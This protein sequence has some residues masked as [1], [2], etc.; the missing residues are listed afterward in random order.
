MSD[1]LQKRDSFK[2]NDDKFVIK[3][4]ENETKLRV[5]NIKKYNDL[6]EQLAKREQALE[7]QLINATADTRAN[8]EAKL[9]K[10]KATNI[11]ELYAKQV[12]LE[13]KYASVKDKTAIIQQQREQA[14]IAAQQQISKILEDQAAG[15]ISQLDAEKKIAEETAKASAIAADSIRKEQELRSAYHQ[16]VMKYGSDQ[17]KAQIQRQRL[18]ENA[19]KLKQTREAKYQELLLKNK[20]K[21]DKLNKK[22]RKAAEKQLQKEVE[23]DEEVKAVKSEVSMADKL[24]PQF[25]ALEKGLGN[26]IVG[27]LQSLTQDME[28][29]MYIYADKG[30][31]INARLNGSMFTWGALSDKISDALKT[32]SVLNQEKMISSVET[33]VQ[34]GIAEDLAQRAFL[35]SVQ[36]NVAS[37]FDAANGTLLRIIRLQDK[38]ST[39][40]RLGME[41]SLNRFLNGYFEDT[42]YLSETF[43][44][45]TDALLEATSLLTHDASAEFEYQIQKWLGALGSEG[46]SSSSATKIAQGIGYLAS[47]DVSALS[48]DSGLQTLLAL[49][50][51]KAG[52]SYSDLLTGGITSNDINDMLYSMVNYLAEIAANQNNVVKS[53]YAHLLGLTQSDLVA[54]LNLAKNSEALNATYA[55]A[56]SYNEM[57]ENAQTNINEIATRMSASQKFQNFYNNFLTSAAVDIGNNPALAMAYQITDFVEGITG[58]T[59]IPFINVYGFGLDINASLEQLIKTGMMGLSFISNGIG[60]IADF[61]KGSSGDYLKIDYWSK[62]KDGKDYDGKYVY[63]DTKIDTSEYNYSEESLTQSARDRQKAE[64]EA[65]GQSSNKGDVPTS[66]ATES[67][68]PITAVEPII[69]AE[70]QPAARDHITEA[71]VNALTGQSASVGDTVNSNSSSSVQNI[72]Q[73]SSSQLV[74]SIIVADMGNLFYDKLQGLFQIESTTS[75]TPDNIPENVTTSIGTLDSD[76]LKY[77]CKIDANILSNVLDMRAK[78]LS[79]AD[80]DVA[81]MDKLKSLKADF[82]IN[83]DNDSVFTAGFAQLL[84]EQIAVAIQNNQGA[85]SQESLAELCKQISNLLNTMTSSDT[86]DGEISLTKLLSDIKT[87]LV[88]CSAS[89]YGQSGFNINVTNTDFDTMIRDTDSAAKKYILY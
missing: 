16:A 15:L 89:T 9:N 1:K 80:I 45:V 2:D 55:E 8:I 37:T 76:E 51:T 44:S 41:A 52:K 70:F 48:S 42:S 68:L 20:D 30:A 5:M 7:E 74:D 19:D 73:N 59:E 85:N 87:I 10:L 35:L 88:T 50:T 21:L 65:R 38:N 86:N 57:K 83:I 11:D 33:L 53:E 46:F 47:G 79:V 31:A 54:A 60:A 14:S 64:E 49:T 66:S 17:E 28:K 63:P 69:V 82:D 58:G 78:G 36:E 39:A 34:A 23:E 3:Q 77:I 81:A 18:Q 61:V 27:G 40:Q 62:D 32:A 6:K 75:I 29:R 84:A 72:T 24:T 43:D 22:D 25:K 56:I 71:I 67:N 12:D 13:Y 4:I 26:A